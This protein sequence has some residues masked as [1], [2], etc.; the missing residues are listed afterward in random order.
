MKVILKEDI[1]NL[2]NMGDIVTV[3]PGYARNYL[4]PRRLAVEASVSNMRGFEHQKRTIQQRANK[5]KNSLH[6]LADKIS[7]RPLIIRVKAGEQEKLFGS[8]T[9][10]DIERS[11]AEA[12]FEIDRK[13]II[14]EEPIKRLG[15]YT[16][17]VRLHPQVTADV[18][19][20]VVRED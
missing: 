20:Q 4:L 7:A 15:E 6:L 17:R 16:V 19:V 14:L 8:V 11:L 18:T 1:D 2:G 9:N 5:I 10:I 12:G 13:R 3:K